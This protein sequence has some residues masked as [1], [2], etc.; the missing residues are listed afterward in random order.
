MWASGGSSFSWNHYGSDSYGQAQTH[1]PSVSSVSR[2]CDPAQCLGTDWRWRQ[3]WLLEYI[4]SKN[5]NRGWQEVGH[6]TDTQHSL[7]QGLSFSGFH[8]SLI[9]FFMAMSSFYV[10][11]SLGRAWLLD[12][13]AK[14]PQDRPHVLLC[15]PIM[16][17][18]SWAMTAK[19]TTVHLSHH[20]ALAVLP[21]PLPCC[22]SG[23]SLWSHSVHFSKLHAIS[24]ID[25]M[26]SPC[27][28]SRTIL[29]CP[30]CSSQIW[31]PQ[32]L[33]QTRASLSQCPSFSLT[34]LHPEMDPLLTT[35]LPHDLSCSLSPR[36]M[37]DPAVGSVGENDKRV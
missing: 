22:P 37:E 15:R 32:N 5:G 16:P 11:E 9:R 17:T 18:L 30:Y 36:A 4:H 35:I 23:H 19:I 3:K 12:H 24:L 2:S 33:S 10:T 26:P 13:A 21:T 29:P 28:W 27:L 20:R 8:A 14:A 25:P 6:R 31:C 1:F 34:S 7:D